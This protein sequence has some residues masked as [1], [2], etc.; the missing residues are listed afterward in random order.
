M[1]LRS[2]NTAGFG[3]CSTPPETPRRRWGGFLLLDVLIGLAVTSFVLLATISLLINAAGAADA[4]KQNTIAY[5]A[6]RQVVENVRNY[7][8]APLAPGE[9]TDVRAFG[10]VPQLDA[11]ATSGMKDARA[12]MS[13]RM[14]RNPVK[15]VTVEVR[16]AGARPRRC[17]PRG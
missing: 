10:A 3:A 6:A 8:G 15:L 9:Y 2:R 17:R 11:T 14:Y 12:T 7:R 16:W 13:I 5:N 1:P 4:A